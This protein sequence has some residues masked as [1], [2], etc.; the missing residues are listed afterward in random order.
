MVYGKF[1]NQT[2]ADAAAFYGVTQRA[3]P[4]FHGQQAL[5]RVEPRTAPDTLDAD[6]AAK[7]LSGYDAAALEAARMMRQQREVI[8]HAATIR[9]TLVESADTLT[10]VRR[11]WAKAGFAQRKQV[12]HALLC[13]NNALAYLP[14]KGVAPIAPAD[15]GTQNSDTGGA[16]GAA[17]ADGA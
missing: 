1:R 15:A 3:D 4:F 6:A 9:D 16:A 10:M 5:W 14:G 12:A 2:E 11:D 8:A 17:P 13:C 7:W